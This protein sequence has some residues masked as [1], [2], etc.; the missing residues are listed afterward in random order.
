VS[1]PGKPFQPSQM[2]AGKAKSLPANI[3]LGWKGY[4]DKHSSLTALTSFI[5]LAL[6]RE[7]IYTTSLS[8]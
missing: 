3:R 4:R 1:V 5:G 6:S 7:H 8:L 2:F